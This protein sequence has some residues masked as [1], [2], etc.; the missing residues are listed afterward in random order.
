LLHLFWAVPLAAVLSLGLLFI[1]GIEECGI[2][3]C[4]GGGFGVAIGGRASFPLFTW[5]IGVVWFLFLAFAPWLR[6]W[7]LRCGIA[8]AVGLALGAFFTTAITSQAAG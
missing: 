1:A 5:A 7:W 8:L 3:G 6:S 2:S 4:G